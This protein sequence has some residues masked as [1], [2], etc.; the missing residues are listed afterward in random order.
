[1]KFLKTTY[2]TLS[3]TKKVI[4]IPN[5]KNTQ[6]VIYKDD[7]PTY[8]VDFY[9]LEIE[10]NAMMNSLVLC[11]KTSLN[12]VLKCINKKNNVNLS[13]PKISRLG[14]KKKLK[15]EPIELNLGPLPEEW[16][17]YSLSD[18]SNVSMT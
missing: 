3:G 1:M 10:S 4:E 9:A 15:S 11:T 2:R 14:Y 7:I 5:K 13:V 8:Y 6:W 17:S 16:L 12:E 18:L